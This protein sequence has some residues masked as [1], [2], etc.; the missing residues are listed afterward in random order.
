[1][2]LQTEK[3]QLGR[4]VRLGWIH[5]LN[6]VYSAEHAVHPSSDFL[7]R[8]LLFGAC[9]RIFRLRNFGVPAHGAFEGEIFIGE[10]VYD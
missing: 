10:S 6:R 1:M 2:P 9:Y 8:K 5:K 7:D 4:L 3:A